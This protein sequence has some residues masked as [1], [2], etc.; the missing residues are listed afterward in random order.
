M[1]KNIIST[2]RNN[3]IISIFP[4]SLVGHG[5]VGGVIGNNNNVNQPLPPCTRILA[6]NMIGDLMR[7]VGVSTF[8]NVSSIFY[9]IL[10]VSMVGKT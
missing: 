7:K 9:I 10:I 3:I 2:V 8:N 1:V 5:M 4:F 6:M